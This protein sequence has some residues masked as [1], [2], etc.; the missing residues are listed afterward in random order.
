MAPGSLSKQELEAMAEGAVGVEQSS[1]GTI[2]AVCLRGEDKQ[3]DVLD[4]PLRSPPPA[5]SEWIEAW[6]YWSW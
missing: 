3:R 6:R 1:D 5:G 4:L 2:A